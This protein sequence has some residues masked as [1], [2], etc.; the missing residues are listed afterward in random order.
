M[1]EIT[2]Q[3]YQEPR[4]DVPWFLVRFEHPLKDVFAFHSRWFS[5]VLFLN[6]YTG[7]KKLPPRIIV[8]YGKGVR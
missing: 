3:K 5:A 7:L 4:D 2:R 1:V 6:R 8:V